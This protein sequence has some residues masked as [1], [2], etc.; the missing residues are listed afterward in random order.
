MVRRPHRQGFAPEP[1]PEP[2]PALKIWLPESPW[3]PRLPEI[4]PEDWQEHWK[5]EICGARGCPVFG[6]DNVQAGLAHL[7]THLNT[8][9]APPDAA[10]RSTMS[11]V[12]EPTPI[13]PPEPPAEQPPSP[14]DPL[15]QAEALNEAL[16]ELSDLLLGACATLE[17]EGWT[18]AQARALVLKTYLGT[19]IPS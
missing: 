18:P 8:N 2:D 10:E 9:P 6:F 11:T 5:C 15:A 19:G 4:H 13:R 17:R 12:P 14:T 3:R 16:K 1:E 7:V